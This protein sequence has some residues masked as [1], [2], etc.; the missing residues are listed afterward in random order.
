LLLRRA[1]RDVEAPCFELFVKKHQKGQKTF[2]AKL[3]N[4][5]LIPFPIISLMISVLTT[6]G[7][8]DTTIPFFESIFSARALV[9]RTLYI[10]D[11]E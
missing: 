11:L 9:K 4:K 1:K 7:F 3:N 2:K 8:K 10:F 5:P 6:P